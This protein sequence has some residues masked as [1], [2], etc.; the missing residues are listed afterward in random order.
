MSDGAAVRE[1]PTERVNNGSRERHE[2]GLTS[3]FAYDPGRAPRQV[4][5]LEP[6]A[7]QLRD[8]EPEA[9]KRDD[10]RVVAR[11]GL[12][13]AGRRLEHPPNLRGL[14]PAGVRAVWGVLQQLS[15]TR[16]ST[17]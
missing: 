10:D 14:G 3:A 8:A 6:Q 9:V 4:S 5:L 15:I 12:G 7:A 1:I 17:G 16:T 13:V 2:F 11:L